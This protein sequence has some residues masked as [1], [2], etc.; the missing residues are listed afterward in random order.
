MKQRIDINVGPRE[1]GKHNSR[2]LRRERKIPAVVY[3]AVKNQN[4][5]IFEGDILR[6]NTRSYENAL[7]NLKS[8]DKNVNGQVVMMKKVDVHPLSRKPEH[9]DL[10]ALDM[11]KPVRISVEV[12]T[13]GKPVGL[14]D[15]GLLNV[16]LRQIEIE[17]LPTQIPEFFVADVSSMGVGDAIHVSSLNI[18]EGIKVI[19][20]LEQTIAV[21]SLLEEESTTAAPAEAAVAAAPAADAKAA[22]A[23]DAAK[24]EKK[25]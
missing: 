17:C 14:A 8:D 6:Y 20:G 3:G 1:I 22:P 4:L 21:V 10:F 24:D 19:T 2:A 25:K 7:F 9:V 16:V 11:N 12:R 13:E 23:A 5:W 15:G 18:P